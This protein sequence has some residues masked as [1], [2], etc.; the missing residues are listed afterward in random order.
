MIER[1]T[2]EQ[3]VLSARRQ[4]FEIASGILSGEVPILEGCHSLAGLRREVE[5]EDLDP[6]F[7]TFGMISSE[8]DALP[9]GSI[10]ARWAPEALAELEPDMQSAIAWATLQA[11]P[12]CDSLVRRFG[13]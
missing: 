10:R 6:D 3:Y 2:H 7:L 4:A 1:M 5:V 9:I 12:A 11:L 8:I 13:A